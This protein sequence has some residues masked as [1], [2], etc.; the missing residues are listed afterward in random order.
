MSKSKIKE[1]EIDNEQI[2]AEL[3]GIRTL[4]CDLPSKIA[5]QIKAQHTHTTNLNNQTISIDSD[6]IGDIVIKAMRNVFDQVDEDYIDHL[7]GLIKNYNNVLHTTQETEQS[8]VRGYNGIGTILNSIGNDIKIQTKEIS[9]NTETL[10][11]LVESCNPTYWMVTKRYWRRLMSFRPREWYSP[12]KIVYVLF[13]ICS[14]L[15][16]VS[17][18][19]KLRAYQK[20]VAEYQLIEN[21]FKDIPEFV[22]EQIKIQDFLK[23]KG[24]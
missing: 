10:R 6:K 23:N 7:S 17:S 1:E 11:I 14:M 18:L 9:K 21:R 2:S 12:R 22:N 20:I 8:V 4:I 5:D 16:N 13:L 24:N 19:M 15:I 3:A